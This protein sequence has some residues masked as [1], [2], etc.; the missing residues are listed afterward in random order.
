MPL[1][2]SMHLLAVMLVSIITVNRLCFNQRASDYKDFK[3]LYKME[4][5]MQPHKSLTFCFSILRI[6][7]LE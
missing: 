7:P 1:K 2:K 4:N 3:R 5:F 6:I